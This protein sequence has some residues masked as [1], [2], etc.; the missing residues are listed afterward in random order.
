MHEYEGRE[1]GFLFKIGTL[2]ASQRSHLRPHLNL[3]TSQILLPNTTTLEVR[4]SVCESGGEGY[5]NIYSIAT[6]K[7]NLTEC[8]KDYTPNYTLSEIYPI[9]AKLV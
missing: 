5:A 7:L 8:L 2:I 4:S 3:T 9:N 6:S 1:G